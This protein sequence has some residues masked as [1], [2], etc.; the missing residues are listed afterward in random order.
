ML[1]IAVGLS[2]FTALVISVLPVLRLSRIDHVQAI[3]VRGASGEASGVRSDTRLRNLLVAGQVAT[4]TMLLVG[5]G[6]LVNSFGRL[7]RVDPGWNASGLLT[8]YLVTPQEYAHT[9]EGDARRGTARGAP[10]DAGCS[11]RGLHVRGPAAGA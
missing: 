6:L 1:A 5:A 10:Q 2:A 7:A 9:T 8:F 11:G 3:G 4:A